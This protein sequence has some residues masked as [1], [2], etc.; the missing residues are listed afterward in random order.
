QH[1]MAAQAEAQ[2]SLVELNR[3]RYEQFLARAQIEMLLASLPQYVVELQHARYV[4]IE[5]E[6]FLK[7][8]ARDLDDRHQ[9]WLDEKGKDIFGFITKLVAFVVDAVCKVYGLP[10]LGSIVNTA[11]HGVID[12]AEGRTAQGI[13]RFTSTFEMAGGKEL[14]EKG[15]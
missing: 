5:A 4:G 6:N 2:K 14:L 12:F 8:L 11:A 9:K 1:A 3:A 10:P 7:E 15:L 13:A